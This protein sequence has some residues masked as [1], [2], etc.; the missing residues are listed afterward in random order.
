MQPCIIHQEPK[1]PKKA[2]C[3]T[4]VAKAGQDKLVTFVDI[5][6]EDDDVDTC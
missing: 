6:T 3:R 1:N 4:N 2:H 5:Q